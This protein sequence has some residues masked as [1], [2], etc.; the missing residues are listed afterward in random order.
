MVDFFTMEASEY[1]ERLDALLSQSGPPS[2]EELQRLTRALRGAALMANQQ[3]IA[4]TAGAFEHLARALREGRQAWDEGTRQLAVRAVDDLKVF[5]RRAREW[6]E[7]DTARA[8][9][10]AA[11]LERAGGRAPAPPRIS[12]AV[13]ADAGTRAFV[14]REGAALASALARAAETLT[15]NP[16]M[17]DPAQAVLHQ[18]Q[19]LRGLATLGEYPP[20]PDLLDGIDRA[21][22][23]V[24]RSTGA[25][26]A[27]ALLDA[28]AKALTQ[29]TRD[30]TTRGQAD[31]D[32]VEIRRFASALKAALGFEPPD[33]P[34]EQLY[35]PDPGPHI[36]EPA[37]P[38]AGPRLG[39]V[40]LVSLGESLKQIGAGVG[41]ARSDSQRE[42][43]VLALVDPLRTLERGTD[44]RLRPAVEALARAGRDV[45]TRGAVAHNPEQLGRL[46]Q[47]IGAAVAAADAGRLGVLAGRLAEFGVP[48][49]AAAA[50]PAASAA[51]LEQETSDLA[52]S[53]LRYRRYV[54]TLGLGTPSLEELLAGPPADPLRAPA[55]RPTP[56]PPAGPLARP[57]VS[58]VS[59]AAPAAPAAPETLVSIM[60]LCYSGSAALDRALSLRERITESLAAGAPA[61]D[62]QALIEEVFDLVRLGHA[63]AR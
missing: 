29:A 3:P 28:A 58:P 27:G 33:V 14:A 34:I 43:R 52:G 46:L 45:I 23:L 51:D 5:V 47:D 15:R 41:S 9:E 35:A 61:G 49:A 19:P 59:P 10:L 2:G 37:P 6:S 11:T 20:L 54:E 4:A 8:R 36:V 22:G 16:A 48:A 17:T 38:V 1:L 24:A 12:A 42:L 26:S 50:A 25:P 32:S 39:E 44:D 55:R 56:I 57:P 18:I 40:E 7:A 62:I 13:A 30:I 60:D 21:A 63:H 53:L 31:A